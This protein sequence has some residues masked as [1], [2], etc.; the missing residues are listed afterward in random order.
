MSTF[1]VG[2]IVEWTLH[3]YVSRATQQLGDLAE[4]PTAT[5]TLPDGTTAAATVA[6]T[7]LG[8]YR[9]TLTTTLPGRH[10]VRWTSTTASDDTPYTDIA[11][12]WPA[13]PRLIISLADARAALNNP[14]TT[15]DD[16]I[17]LYIAAATEQIEDRIGPVLA[18]TVT[19]TRSGDGRLCI[20]LDKLPTAIASV[21][22]DG[23]TLAATAYSLD[24]SG[25]LWR[26]SH[27]GGGCWSS[28]STRNVVIT[29]TVG[30]TTVAPGVVKAA[31]E[32]VKH[33]YGVSQQAA[34]PSFDDG[35]GEPAYSPQSS[36][37]AILDA[38]TPHAAGRTPGIA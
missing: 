1:E 30:G 4:T 19:E 9:A 18:D 36:W 6:R 15:A 23:T 26:G 35:S 13:D 22:E 20:A 34:R 11:D 27:K 14:P 7:G 38:L 25:I 3:T 24:E 28:T 8:T 32:M 29:Y 10:T 5:V 33:Q 21:V 12:V 31:R 2:Q 37:F 16:E 17:R